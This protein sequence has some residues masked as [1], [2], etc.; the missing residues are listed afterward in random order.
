MAP[1][2]YAGLSLM[3]ATAI[4]KFL[5]KINNDMFYAGQKQLQGVHQFILAK[6]M[7]T[8]VAMLE[9]HYGHTSSIASA[10]ELTKRGNFR[11]GK[12]AKAVEWLMEEGEEE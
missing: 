11:R 9:K 6:N 12:S 4:D 10:A 7:G 1:Q 8:S 2:T 3:R 5:Y